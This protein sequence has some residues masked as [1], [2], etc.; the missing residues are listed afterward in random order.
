M[1]TMCCESNLSHD[2]FSSEW[3]TIHAD[4][5]ERKKSE[6][7]DSPFESPLELIHQHSNHHIHY[8]RLNEHSRNFSNPKDNPTHRKREQSQHCETYR[9]KELWSFTMAVNVLDYD[10]FAITAIVIVGVQFVF[11]VIAATFQ[12]DKLTDIAGGLNF[13][14]VALLTFFLGQINRS[15]KVS[16]ELVDSFWQ[17]LFDRRMQ[18]L[19]WQK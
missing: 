3:H 13:A 7:D 17:R 1:F 14:I 11:F 5:K 15:T 16:F 4:V 6:H 19:S 10:H 18:P 2:G 9:N 8:L 12:F